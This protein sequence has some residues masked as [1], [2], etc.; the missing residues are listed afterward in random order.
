[1]NT[2]NDHVYDEKCRKLVQE[3]KKQNCPAAIR[4]R[5]IVKFP[6]FKVMSTSISFT[7]EFKISLL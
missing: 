1:L 6:Q 5:R 4:M 2:E 7:T 3:T